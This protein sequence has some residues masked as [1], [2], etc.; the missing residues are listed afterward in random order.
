MKLI[1]SIAFAY[2][3]GCYQATAQD[4]KTLDSLKRILKKSTIVEQ[5]QNLNKIS[6]AYFRVNLDSAIS[7]GNKSINFSNKHKIYKELAVGY[8]YLGQMIYYKGNYVASLSNF[9]KFRT[10]ALQLKDNVL[11]AQAINNI[12]GV[13]IDQGK[14]DEAI[15]KYEEVLAISKKNNDKKGQ[16]LGYG[17]LAFAYRYIGNNGKAI[18]YIFEQIKIDEEINNKMG[19]AYSYQQLVLLYNQRNDLVNTKKYLDLSLNKFQELNDGRNVAVSYDLYASYFQS[20]NHIKKAIEYEKMAIDLANK[21]QDKRSIAIF[22]SKLSNLYFEAEAFELAE[23][24]FVQAINLHES[25]NLQKTVAGAYIGYGKSLLKLNKLE[26]AK[27]N[28]D[29]GLAIAIS[30]KSAVDKRN[31]YEAL[32][33]YY[34]KIN[35]SNQAI[36]TQRQYIAVKDSLLNESNSKQ[37]NELNTIYQ[38]QKKEQKILLLD[39]QNLIQGLEL[40]KSKLELENESLENDKKAL[41]ISEQNFILQKNKV[42]IAQKQIETRAK[43]QQIKLLAT[44]NE[45]QKL[46]L[47]KR[48]IFLIIIISILL[49]SILLAYLFYSRN[50]LKQ[51]ARLQD[52]VIKQ[53]DLATKAILNAEE[54]ERKRI[55]NELHDGL[56]QM[57]SAVKMNLSALTEDLNFKN[58]QSKDMFDKTLSLVDESCKEVRSISHQMAPNVLLKSGLAT[59]VRDFISKIDSRKLKIKLETFG[60]QERLDQNIETVLYRVIQETVNNVIKHA[61]ASSLDIQLSKDEEGINAMI[62][63]NG[64]GFNTSEL[65]KFEGIGLKNIRSR[66][67]YLKGSVDF[68]STPSSGTLVAIFI[69]F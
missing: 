28:L 40:N 10:I 54:S 59:A 3:L 68:S 49:V 23:K 58:E 2:F 36:K 31:A 63:D 48:N 61:E 67:E 30:Q 14:T 57:F 24:N 55:S 41:Q 5:A 6:S 47:L 18:S 1:L 12:A 7:Y 22:Q 50:K 39:K 62:E 69:P 66:V 34:I 11:I 65:E 20:T 33:E 4:Q 51:E 46:E 35:E 38:T 37:I 53:Q 42:L 60:L 64:R 45:V 13:L 15:Q 32:T 27:S 56:G 17:N 25:I 26:Q 43:A 29:K 8:N 19:L 52:E 16:S 21:H 9:E 44:Q